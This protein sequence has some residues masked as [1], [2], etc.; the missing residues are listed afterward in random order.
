MPLESFLSTRSVPNNLAN[1]APGSSRSITIGVSG[2]SR[3]VIA[4]VV[5]LALAQAPTPPTF[6][7]AQPDLFGVTGGMPNAWADFDND[8]DLDQFVGFR[9]RPNRLYRQDHGRF[10]DVA[11]AVGLAGRPAAEVFTEIRARKNKF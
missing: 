3:T 11:A 9:G 4:C 6:E 2:F 8:G 1:V 5:F 10:E 7:L